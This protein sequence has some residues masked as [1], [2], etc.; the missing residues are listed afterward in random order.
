MNITFIKTLL[1][2]EQG[3]HKPKCLIVT[4]TRELAIQ[5]YNEVKKFAF[6]SPLKS[7]LAYGGEHTDHHLLNTSV[8]CRRV[9][10]EPA[11]LLLPRVRHPGSHAG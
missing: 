10:W 3:C 9:D 7:A 4:P 1:R 6:S 2:S 8:L 11:G 5:I